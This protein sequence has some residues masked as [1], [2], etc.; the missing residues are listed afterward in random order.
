MWRFI[1]N[2]LPVGLNLVIAPY[3]M[4]GFMHKCMHGCMD[5]CMHRCMH[6]QAPVRER[7]DACTDACTDVLKTRVPL[8]LITNLSDSSHPLS[9]PQTFFSTPYSAA[10]KERM[11]MSIHTYICIHIS[12]FIHLFIDILHIFAYT[13]IL[14]SIIF[15][16]L[17][18]HRSSCVY[19][20]RH[21]FLRRPVDNIS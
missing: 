12:I 21:I 17:Y 20:Y 8:C 19:S 1:D 18:T 14:I 9:R 3:K 7:T 16:Y 15:L 2:P 11:Y 5:G 10:N 4:Y 6:V 13:S